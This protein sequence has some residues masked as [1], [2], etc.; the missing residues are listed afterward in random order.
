MIPAAAY[1]SSRSLALSAL[2]SP[3]LCA[4]SEAL[5]G[6]TPVYVEHI[7]GADILNDQTGGEPLAVGALPVLLVVLLA[8]TAVNGFYACE[9]HNSI[10]WWMATAR[11]RF[12]CVH[13]YIVYIILSIYTIVVRLTNQS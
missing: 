2:P 12:S 13:K 5:E 9:T 4:A 10:R 6:R 3:H 8:T 11:R 1:F 7:S